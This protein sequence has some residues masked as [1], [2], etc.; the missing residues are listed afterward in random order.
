MYTRPR[1]TTCKELLQ[2]SNRQA[3]QGNS[4]GPEFCPTLADVLPF[5]SNF[6]SHARWVCW[7]NMWPDVI[8][9]FLV[10]WHIW[11][12]YSNERKCNKTIAVKLQGRIRCQMST[13]YSLSPTIVLLQLK[14]NSELKRAMQI[15]YCRRFRHKLNQKRQIG[16]GH[17]VIRN[18]RPV[19]W[20]LW[21]T[22]QFACVQLLCSFRLT[23]WL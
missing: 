18:I 21:L 2:T 19:V 15:F 17:G 7:H 6:C 5:V 20:L 16:E 4:K 13:W 8:S 23:L 1:R 3:T 22:V 14:Y 9:A 10:K 11:T 12:T